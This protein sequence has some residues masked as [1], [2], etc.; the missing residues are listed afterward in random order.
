MIRCKCCGFEMAMNLAM[1]FEEQT[2][3][4]CPMCR[5]ERCGPGSDWFIGWTWRPVEEFREQ[6][7]RQRVQYVA[8]REGEAK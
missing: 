6:F 3:K 2:E 5:N 4:G 8:S 7:N 1:T